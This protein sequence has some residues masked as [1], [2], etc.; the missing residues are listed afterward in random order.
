MNCYLKKHLKEEHASMKTPALGGNMLT[1]SV[2]GG[3]QICMWCCLHTRDVANSLTRN[4][5]TDHHPDY[6]IKAQE[7]SE[8][9]LDS[10]WETCS[11]CHNAQ[12]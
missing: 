8:R 12:A 4:Y 7:V 5:A 3:N 2:Y 6:A 9:D 11:R 10:I 1:C